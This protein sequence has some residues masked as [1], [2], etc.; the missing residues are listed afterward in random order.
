M[1]P[2]SCPSCGRRGNVPPDRLNSRLHCKKCDAVFYMDATGQVILGDPADKEKKGRAAKPAKAR[3]SEVSMDVSSELAEIAEKVPKPIR[4]GGTV[5]L[6]LALIYFFVPMPNLGG[7][8]LPGPDDLL[9][10]AG[11][12][13]E[14]AFMDQKAGN[15]RKISAPGTETDARQ[16]LQE[17]RPKFNYT[18]PKRQGNIV[19]VSGSI[20]EQDDSAGTAL[21]LVNLMPPNPEIKKN[22][23]D[24][25][26]PWPGYRVKGEFRL[27]L[28]WTKGADGEWLLDGTKTLESLGSVPEQT[29]VPAKTATPKKA[30]AARKS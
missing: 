11:Y 12:V 22:E 3:S 21:V 19:L 18:G 16:W 5:A 27:P 9:G 1:I 4:I 28:Y 15:L 29:S 14:H 10:R 8:P 7:A 17:L 25:P 6:M 30:S 20:S 26:G 2:M 24:T 13:A 23:A